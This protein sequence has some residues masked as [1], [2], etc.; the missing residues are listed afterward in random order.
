MK[1]VKYS[2]VLFGI[3]NFW[4]D[5]GDSMAWECLSLKCPQCDRNFR[6]FDPICA[7]NRITYPN[8]C[9]V[10]CYNEKRECGGEQGKKYGK[11]NY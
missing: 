11:N 4:I 9:W 1:S 5:S 6:I 2:I 10:N 8:E 3:L 7:S